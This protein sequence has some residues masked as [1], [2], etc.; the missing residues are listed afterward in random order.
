MLQHCTSSSSWRFFILLDRRCDR[1]GDDTDGDNRHGD[2]RGEHSIECGDVVVR[3]GVVGNWGLCVGGEQ[4][5]SSPI[6]LLE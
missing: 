6:S 2:R 3:D 4:G 5:G 1:S